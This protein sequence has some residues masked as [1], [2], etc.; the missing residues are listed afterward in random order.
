MAKGRNM[1]AKNKAEE[2]ESRRVR[3]SLRDL[4]IQFD[5]RDDWKE[6]AS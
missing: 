6:S 3:G 1:P 4:H 5:G 2:N